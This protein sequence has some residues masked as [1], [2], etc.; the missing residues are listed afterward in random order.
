MAVRFSINLEKNQYI[1]PKP[2]QNLIAT[3][4]LSPKAQKNLKN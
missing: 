4:K 2:F 3:E 1:S